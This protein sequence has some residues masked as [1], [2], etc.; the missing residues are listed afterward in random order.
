MS[1]GIPLAVWVI[2]IPLHYTDVNWIVTQAIGMEKLGTS[3]HP[4]PGL[5]HCTQKEI[6]THAG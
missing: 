3:N 1:W 2:N 6:Q 4:Q 5:L